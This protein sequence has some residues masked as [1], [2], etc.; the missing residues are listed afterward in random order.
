MRFLIYVDHYP[1]TASAVR[2][3]NLLAER[4]PAEVV[5]LGVARSETETAATLTA[6]AE[7]Q[8][9]L[10][11]PVEVKVRVGHAANEILAEAKAQAYTLVI[12]RSRGRRGWVRAA[13]GSLSGRVARYSPI[14]VLIVCDKPKP[15]IGHILACTGGSRPGERVARWGG[16]LAHWL[17]ADF[18]ILHVMSQMAAT[19][20]ANTLGL[21]E[22]AEQAIRAQT[23]EGQ[24]MQQELTLAQAEGLTAAALHPKIRHGL[25]VEEVLAE[26]KKGQYDMLVIGGHQAPG[27][28][29]GWGPVRAFL[30]EDIADQ[31]VAGVRQPI[32]VIKGD[33]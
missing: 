3:G 5:L 27:P 21:Q 32:L 19:T 22:T 24:H 10:P 14:P 26:T 12:L 4:A 16:R 1:E 6:L 15:A 31:I 23:H 8:K 33:V 11:K 9:L 20:E 7:A 28:E 25:V 2:L 18:T 13:L 30:L 17:G 29:S